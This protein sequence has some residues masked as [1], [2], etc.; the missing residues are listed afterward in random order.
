MIA[1]DLE[2]LLKPRIVL[3]RARCNRCGD[4]IRS[5]YRWDFVSCGCGYL[6]V[7]GGRAYLKR[8]IRDVQGEGPYRDYVEMCIMTKSYSRRGLIVHAYQP[9]DLDIYCTDAIG[10]LTIAEAPEDYVVY[11]AEGGSTAW[12]PAEFHTNHAAVEFDGTTLME[13]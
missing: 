4:V 2:D 7:D 10:R 1:S 9:V 12:K 8:S 3:N 5:S 6:S 13:H 11:E